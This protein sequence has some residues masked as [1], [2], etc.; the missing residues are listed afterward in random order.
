MMVTHG[1]SWS[2][3]SVERRR[4]RIINMSLFAG[5]MYIRANMKLSQDLTPIAVG[6]NFRGNAIAGL[7]QPSLI[8]IFN[9][10][11]AET[12]QLRTMTRTDA[13]SKCSSAPFRKRS[14]VP[15][16]PQFSKH[17]YPGFVALS[18]VICAFPAS[19][20]SF[21]SETSEDRDVARQHARLDDLEHE[22]REGRGIGSDRGGLLS[23][24][25]QE[26]VLN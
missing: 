24:A 7:L 21:V 15:P 25:M 13:S 12:I 6:N 20:F 3:N 17:V 10:G 5:F 1:P 26:E 8:W 14:L 18:S 19:M 2:I 11:S 16:K 9:F 23:N 4:L 22:R